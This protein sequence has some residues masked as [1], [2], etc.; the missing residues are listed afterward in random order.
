M[1][2]DRGNTIRITAAIVFVMLIMGIDHLV[3]AFNR[4]SSAK[5]IISTC[6]Q[7]RFSRA[8]SFGSIPAG[9][10]HAVHDTSGRLTA[11]GMIAD[12]NHARWFS[13]H[14]TTRTFRGSLSTRIMAGFGKMF[15]KEEKDPGAVKG[16]DLKILKYPHPKL[17]GENAKIEAFDDQLINTAAEMLLVMYAADG[18]GLAAPQ[19]GINKRLM[20]F[21]EKGEPDEE[22]YEMIL[23]NPEIVE[24]S[25]SKTLGEEGCLSFP[26]I[27]GQVERHDWVTVDYQT[28]SGDRVRTKFE[29]R[30]AIIFQHEYDHLDKVLFIDRLI[31]ADKERNSRRLQKYVKKYGPGGA[32]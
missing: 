3:R 25:E 24:T 9:L 6:H 29:G 26:L 28:L 31:P 27:H 30:P 14:K 5:R 12:N 18:I 16:T 7:Q 2:I 11:L 23:V 4:H 21:N 13:R 19:V 15:T 1:L 20:V 8:N 17:R 10:A 22:E 32:P